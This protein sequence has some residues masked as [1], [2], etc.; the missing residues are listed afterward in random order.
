MGAG[1]GLVGGDHDALAGGQAVVLDHVRRA[2]RAERVGDL[3]LVGASR[4]SAVGTPAAAMTS[5]AKALLPSRRAAARGR[6]EAGDAPGPDGVRDAGDQRRLGADDDE[7]GGELVG[8]GGHRGRRHGVD[9]P[10]QGGVDARVARRD[11]HGRH[12]GIGLQGA[13]QRVLAGAGPDDEDSH[14]ASP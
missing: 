4:A 10:A 3:G 7:V 2:E 8:E 6:P 1:L 14:A 5:F 12:G 11:D 13:Q 9:R